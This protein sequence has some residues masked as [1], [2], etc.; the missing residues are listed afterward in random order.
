MNLQLVNTGSSAQSL[1]DV[2]IRYWFDDS[3]S[4]YT[5]WCDWAQIGCSNLTHSVS[6]NGTAAGANRY[7]KV[8]VTGGTLAA[9]ASTGD[10]QLRLHRAYWSNL[11]EADDYSHGTASAYTDAPKIGVYSGGQLVWGTAP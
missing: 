5:T 7:L 1:K 2:E 4:S 6:T 10:I 11:N 3:A 9:G 8:N